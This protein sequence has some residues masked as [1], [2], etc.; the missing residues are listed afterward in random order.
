MTDDRMTDNPEKGSSSGD[1]D[2]DKREGQAPE[3][4]KEGSSRELPPMDFS[5]FILSLSTSAL[6]N[7]GEIQ[8]PVTKKVEKEL[9]LARQ[10]IDII[11]MLREKTRGNLTQEEDRLINNVLYDLRLRYC[12]A[13]E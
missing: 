6:M 4:G 2:T 13:V 11:D 10:T 5:T 3:G 1:R 7:L 9:E 8:N 12:K